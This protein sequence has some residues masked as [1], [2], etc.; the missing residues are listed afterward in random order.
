MFVCMPCLTTRASSQYVSLRG[1]RYSGKVKQWEEEDNEEEEE[2]EDNDSEDDD[3]AEEGDEGGFSGV[4]GV[5]AC[6]NQSD[7]P[8]LF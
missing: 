4:S 7:T 6:L 8:T 2:E 3:D 5:A 1:H